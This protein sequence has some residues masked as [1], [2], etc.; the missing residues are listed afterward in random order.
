MVIC[1]LALLVLGPDKLPV[2]MRE[3]GKWMGQ[4]KAMSNSFRSEIQ[5]AMDDPLEAAARDYG[6]QMVERE[7]VEKAAEESALRSAG[8]SAAVGELASPAASDESDDGAESAADTPA[9]KPQRERPPGPSFGSAAPPAA[10][11]T[12]LQNGAAAAAADLAA[13]SDADTA[14][15]AGGD[16]S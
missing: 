9:P 1:L 10:K 8:A 2:A 5:A 12:D 11:R 16:A 6:G 7:K 15:D 4:L 3:A 13:A 14:D